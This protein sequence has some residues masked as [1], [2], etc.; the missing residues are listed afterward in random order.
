[1]TDD[2]TDDECTAEGDARPTAVPSRRALSVTVAWHPDPARIGRGVT[3]P[4]DELPLALGRLAPMLD[5]GLSLADRRVSRTPVTLRSTRSG[6]LVLG[7]G[8]RTLAL[9]GAP[10]GEGS[11]VDVAGVA[12]GFALSLGGGATVWVQSGNRS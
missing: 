4:W 3:V 2:P 7:T 10:A 8:G 1:M 5:D 9:N 11:V 6:A 12:L